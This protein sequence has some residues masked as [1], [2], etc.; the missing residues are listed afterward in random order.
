MIKFAVI[1]S[2]SVFTPELVIK[3][4]DNADKMGKMSL[5][6]MDIDINRQEIVAGLCKRLLKNHKNG[7]NITITEFENLDD[8][9]KDSD[10]VLLQLRQGGVDARIEDERLGRKYGLPFTETISIC[11]Y[12]TF[13]RTYYEFE[14]IGQAILKHAPDAYI[15]NF[16]NPAGQLSETLYGMGIKN[17]IGVCNGFMGIRWDIEHSLNLKPNEYLMNWRG[18]NHLTIVDGIYAGGKNRI[19]DLLNAFP[20]KYSYFNKDDLLSLGA[21]LNSY[22]AHYLNSKDKPSN[23]PQEP[24]EQGKLR[25]ETVKELEYILLDEYKN[26][27]TVPETLSK[28][29]GFGYSSAVVN[30]IRAICLNESSVHY[31]VVRNRSCLP[32]LPQDAFV[33]VPILV[34]SCGAFPIVTDEVPAYV[35]NLM[36]A[37]K[38]YERILIKAAKERCKKGMFEAMM[39]HPLMNSF[40]IARPLLD[41]CIEVNKKYLPKIK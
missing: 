37:I 6:F 26:S 18:L 17:I 8:C 13:L 28:R 29:G 22:I 19:N 40:K 15:L 10:Y 5:K 3:L 31:S 35:Q 33:E 2:G 21:V 7:D 4:A 20:E 36:I 38:S 27:D 41:D 24:K 39:T 12:A 9:L 34:N 30:I 16:T 25:S 32:F 1:G 14:K 11:G 23:E